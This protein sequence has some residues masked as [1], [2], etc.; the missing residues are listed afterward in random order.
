MFFFNTDCHVI[1]SCELLCNW[2]QLVDKHVISSAM[3]VTCIEWWGWENKN[4]VA[5]QQKFL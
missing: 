2:R 4:K 1:R 5:S 3:I